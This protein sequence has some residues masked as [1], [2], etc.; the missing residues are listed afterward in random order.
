[1][2]S[3]IYVLDAFA[4]LD[5]AAFL[6]SRRVILLLEFHHYSSALPRISSASSAV[7]RLDSRNRINP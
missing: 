4:V 6:N 1:M 3:P 2:V 7:K 5:D